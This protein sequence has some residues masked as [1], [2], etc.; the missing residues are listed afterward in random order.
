MY[1]IQPEPF[2]QNGMITEDQRNVARMCD[3]AQRIC[4]ARNPVLVFADHIK[5][6]AGNFVRIKCP[7]Q[8]IGESTQFELRRCDQVELREFGHVH[9]WCPSVF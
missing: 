3:F 6:Y 9:S 5:S 8:Q 2:D 1:A 7:C 4:G